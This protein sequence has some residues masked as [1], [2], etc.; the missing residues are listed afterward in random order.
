VLWWVQYI[1]FHCFLI[2]VLLLY[3]W[4]IHGY[5]SKVLWLC[6]QLTCLNKWSLHIIQ[7]YTCD[8]FSSS[9]LRLVIEFLSKGWSCGATEEPAAN[10]VVAALLVPSP[11]KMWARGVDE[12]EVGVCGWSGWCSHGRSSFGSEDTRRPGAS[13]LLPHPPPH[14]RIEVWVGAELL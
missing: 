7:L 11:R 1:L 3:C 10:L 12:V 5:K 14:L 2:M 8:L 6:V 13:P 4:L 9:C